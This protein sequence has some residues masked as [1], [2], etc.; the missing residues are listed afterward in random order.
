MGFSSASVLQRSVSSEIGEAP[1]LATVPHSWAKPWQFFELG[2]S[3][4][5]GC[6]V[7]GLSYYTAFLLLEFGSLVVISFLVCALNTE[8]NTTMQKGVNTGKGDNGPSA[9]RMRMSTTTASSHHSDAQVVIYIAGC[10]NIEFNKF[11]FFQTTTQHHLPSFT[12]HQHSTGH[13]T[14][15]QSHEQHGSTSFNSTAGKHSSTFHHH[16]RY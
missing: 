12:T 13:G 10:I 14:T 7:F 16:P 11:C 8:F 15:T 6:H 2:P 9:K 5:S 3:L 4:L 1:F